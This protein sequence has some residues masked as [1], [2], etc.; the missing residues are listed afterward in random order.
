MDNDHTSPSAC[1]ISAIIPVYNVEKYLTACMQSI[2]SQTLTQWEAIF[3][4]DGSTDLSGKTLDAFA[5]QDARVKVIHKPNG[6]VSTARNAG[7]D[8]ATAPFVVMLDADDFID[9]S[10]FQKLYDSITQHDCGMAC[11]CMR[12]IFSNGA[13]EDEKSTFA[14]GKHPATPANIYAFY[15]RSPAAK[16]YRRD[17][18]ERYNIRFPDVP[19]L[20]YKHLCEH[21]TNAAHIRR[22]SIHLIKHLLYLSLWMQECCHNPEHVAS[23]RQHEKQNAQELAHLSPL[24]KFFIRLRIYSARLV[25]RILRRL[26]K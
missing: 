2:A 25:K 23:L 1:L 15:M 14:T 11:C 16:I 7:L 9:P 17:I 8:A 21:S 18:I 6:G 20:V 3:V 24:T 10:T 4:D 12:K 26:G 5:A 22:W 19:I 13:H